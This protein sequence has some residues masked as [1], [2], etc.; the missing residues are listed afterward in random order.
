MRSI[1]FLKQSIIQGLY[2]FMYS[3]CTLTR[4]GFHCLLTQVIDLLPPSQKHFNSAI[5]LTSH[6]PHLCNRR[7]GLSGV[8]LY[9]F[10]DDSLCLLIVYAFG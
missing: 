1:S 3:I 7:A 5:C 10:A 9:P 8:S 4:H 2:T 6:I